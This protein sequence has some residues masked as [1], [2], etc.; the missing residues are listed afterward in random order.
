MPVVSLNRDA[1]K[2]SLSRLTAPRSPGRQQ[3]QQPQ[4]QRSKEKLKEAVINVEQL[5][6][7]PLPPPALATREFDVEDV[8]DDDDIFPREQ[9]G[10]S[11]RDTMMSTQHPRGTDPPSSFSAFGNSNT[12]SS[13]TLSNNNNNEAKLQ[14][15]QK[16]YGPNTDIYRDVLKVSPDATQAEIREAFFCLRYD[17]YQKHDDD[18]GGGGSGLTSEERRAVEDKM[19][20]IAGA[21]HIVGDANR[22]R[23]YDASLLLSAATAKTAS[24]SS[25]TRFGGGG[26]GGGGGEAHRNEETDEMGFPISPP[27]T[28]KNNRGSTASAMRLPTTASTTSSSA[29]TT[30]PPPARQLSPRQ[31]RTISSYRRDVTTG[32]NESRPVVARPVTSGGVNARPSLAAVNDN[33]EGGGKTIG[34]RESPQWADFGNG[35][36]EDDNDMMRMNPNATARSNEEDDVNN[37]DDEE[38]PIRGR[39][40]MNVREQLLYNSQLKHSQRKQQ[41]HGSTTAA[42]TTTTSSSSLSPSRFASRLANRYNRSAARDR[43]DRYAEDDDPEDVYAK[44]TK[45]A[46]F[47][48]QARK[49]SQ[50]A[51]P[52]GVDANLDRDSN[53]WSKKF[54]G[55]RRN[56]AD[57]GRSGF[58]STKGGG[59]EDEDDDYQAKTTTRMATTKLDNKNRN[60]DQK[61]DID[62]NYDD[63]DEGE[64]ST[65]AS[66]HDEDT[67]TYD[68]DTQTYDDDTQTCDDTTIGGSTWASAD[69]S[70]VQPDDD[71][72]DPPRHSPG[73]KKGNIPEPILKS[74]L[75]RVGQESDSKRRVTIHSHRGRGEDEED[76]SLFEGA[77]C[78]NLL[79]LGAIKEEVNGTYNDFT[80]AL[81]QVKNAF[82]INPDD[83]DRLADKIR[84]AKIELGENYRR[85]ANERRGIG[86]S[87]G[88]EVAK[89]GGSGVG[90]RDKRK[91]TKKVSGRAIRTEF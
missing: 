84:D 35:V 1:I 56:G 10:G 73:H 68:D 76:F 86:S 22:R 26:G 38:V 87:S 78:P 32:M 29:P 36:D 88:T 69:I 43:G 3:Q 37:N 75:K 54:G 53:V 44:K 13:T 45:N 55:G 39:N 12:I 18:Q 34:G 7:P 17:L 61:N 16:V 81:H 60:N 9:L 57:S 64:E 62:N 58:D 50:L 33:A 11:S 15:I 23:A 65:F 82:V 83:I 28:A 48:Q 67:R 77:M 79:S 89:V 59:E 90:S 91:T 85:Q 31:R 14:T 80:Q 4:Q 70:Y 2:N 24:N 74:G 5:P 25:T 46:G 8:D 71:E 41:S 51:S 47:D 49:P 27:T 72:N 40:N 42:T 19:D 21:F 63:D 52:T 66:S 30:R 20:A 6:P